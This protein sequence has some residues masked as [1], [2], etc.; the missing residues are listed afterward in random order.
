MARR[1]VGLKPWG[2]R[3]GVGWSLG[4]G[5]GREGGM[6]GDE[7]RERE[8]GMKIQMQK[9]SLKSVLAIANQAS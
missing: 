4:V 3:M 1:E 8:G 6:G 7:R 5:E 9:H 2:W